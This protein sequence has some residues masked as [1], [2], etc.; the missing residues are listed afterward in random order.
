ML[1]QVV[2]YTHAYCGEGCNP[3]YGSCFGNSAPAIRN[4]D[5]YEVPR[6]GVFT[7]TKEFTFTTDHELPSGLGISTG[8]A[9]QTTPLPHKF[10]K[11]NVDVSDG[12]MTLTVPGGQSKSPILCGEVFTE[13]D[14]IFYGSVRTYAV[15]SKVPGTVHG[16]RNHPV[17]SSQLTSNAPNNPSTR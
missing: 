6:V 8:G 17:H 12:F 7:K 16:K 15:F 10:I 11:A 13:Q 4:G 5:T 1:K 9:I 2:G 14:R 3:A